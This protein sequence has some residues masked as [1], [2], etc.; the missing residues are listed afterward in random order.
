MLSY[1]LQVDVENVIMGIPIGSTARNE[2]Q[3]KWRDL[4]DGNLTA[5]GVYKL[6]SEGNR[7]VVGEK[8]VWIWKLFCTQRVHTFIW[9]CIH[10]R[11]I[12]NKERARRG[13][14]DF[15][16]CFRCYWVEEDEIHVIQDCIEVTQF[17]KSHVPQEFQTSFFPAPKKDWFRFNCC[18]KRIKSKVRGNIPWKNS[19]Y[20]KIETL[21]FFNANMC[22]PKSLWFKSRIWWR[23]FTAFSQ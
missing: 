16:I 21:S 17:W 4:T 13:F 8:W 1:K 2:D 9:L 6:L 14:T 12:V 18:N 15:T 10:N 19:S 7:N 11:L 22:P 23:S 5:K 3:L 20:G